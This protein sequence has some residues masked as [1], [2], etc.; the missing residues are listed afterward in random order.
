MYQ[1]M[2]KKNFKVKE[3][4]REPSGKKEGKQDKE[5]EKTT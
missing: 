3:M 2:R 4:N 5:L 1:L